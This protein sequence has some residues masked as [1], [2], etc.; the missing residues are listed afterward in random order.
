MQ[1]EIADRQKDF[2]KQAQQRALTNESLMRC[3]NV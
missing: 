1:R 2:K 3:Y